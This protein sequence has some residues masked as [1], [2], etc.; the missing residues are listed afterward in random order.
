MNKAEFVLC[1]T[2]NL[3]EM[4]QS[5]DGHKEKDDKNSDSN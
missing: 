1:K 2:D 3:K 4:T 5:A